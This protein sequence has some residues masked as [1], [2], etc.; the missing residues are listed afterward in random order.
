MHRTRP[1]DY[2]THAQLRREIDRQYVKFLIN[3]LNTLTRQISRMP[4]WHANR[5]RL[6]K[7][8]AR[9][10]DA[11]IAQGHLPARA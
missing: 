4:G 5:G 1:K 6:V 8:A 11:L 9:T 7:Q 3:K 10:R 2:R